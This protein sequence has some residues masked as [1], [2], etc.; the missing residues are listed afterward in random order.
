VTIAEFLIILVLAFA[1]ELIQCFSWDGMGNYLHTSPYPIG[2]SR[3]CGCSCGSS[4]SGLGKY[5]CIC[6]S[7]INLRMHRFEPGSVELKTA[8]ILGS[9]GIVASTAGSSPRCQYQ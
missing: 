5:C 2:F 9:F 7:I 3:G 1:I 6:F 8:A 4:F